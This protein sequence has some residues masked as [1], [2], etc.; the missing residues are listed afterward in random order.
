MLNIMDHISCLYL[1]HAC[2]QFDRIW[3]Y[4]NYEHNIPW[5]SSTQLKLHVIAP[6]VKRPE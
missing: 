1:C 6:L 4:I 3:G 2:V 5:F